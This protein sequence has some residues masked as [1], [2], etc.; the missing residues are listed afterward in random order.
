M[1]TTYNGLNFEMISK[2]VGQHICADGSYGKTYKLPLKLGQQPSKKLQALLAAE[3]KKVENEI[4]KI[5]ENIDNLSVYRALAYHIRTRSVS[6]RNFIH[7][8]NLDKFI[9]VATGCQFR[10][11]KTNYD[12]LLNAGMDKENAREVMS[13]NQ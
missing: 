6:Y 2:Y 3:E 4:A 11:E 12:Q 10:H 7:D 9:R 8:D 5:T 1:R 13:V